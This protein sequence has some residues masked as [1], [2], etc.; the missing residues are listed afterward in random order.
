MLAIPP[1]IQPR[2]NQLYAQ[3]FSVIM[4][5]IAGLHALMLFVSLAYTPLGFMPLVLSLN[6]LGGVIAGALYLYPRSPKDRARYAAYLLVLPAL[7]VVASIYLQ[8]FIIADQILLTFCLLL[9]LGTAFTTH[10]RSVFLSV[11]SV[12]AVLFVTALLL[13]EGTNVQLFLP[14]LVCAGALSFWAFVERRLAMVQ[15]LLAQARLDQTQQLLAERGQE[16]REKVA[17]AEDASKMKSEFIASTSHEIKTALSGI[18]SAMDALSATEISDEQK[19][20]TNT[21]HYS[22]KALQRVLDDIMDTTKLE[23]GELEILAEPFSPA[24][25]V[26]IATSLRMPEARKKGLHLTSHVQKKHENINLFGD[27]TRL[28]QVLQNLLGN[29]IRYTETGN[30]AVLLEISGRGGNRTLR[31]AVQDTGAGMTPDEMSEIFKLKKDVSQLLYRG[32][33]GGGLGLSISQELMNI[34]GGKL[35]AESEKGTGSVFYMEISLPLVK[36]VPSEK[37]ESVDDSAQAVKKLPKTAAHILIAEDN[38]INR[39]LIRS[40]LATE[41]YELEFVSDGLQALEVVSSESLIPDLILMD[42]QM[43]IMDGREATRAIR[44]L[45]DMDRAS[46]PIVAL[47]ANVDKSGFNIYA[48]D[49]IDEV[50]P[51]PIDQG[52]L[53][54]TIRQVLYC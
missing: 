10:A 25:L 46:V 43:P 6:V 27:G 33:A 48:E 42:I 21:A 31:I 50:V 8:L 3:R 1:E 30:V 18:I 35:Y 47:T 2:L 16:L 54:K 44:A 53:L 41:N 45:D 13:L 36:A 28:A 15:S 23:G 19:V 51:K 17:V 26:T 14:A 22:A 4:L 34:M 11:L 32:H 39:L 5:L 29:A 7:M 38:E 52:Q 37:S 9:M 49:G 24:A 12:Q 20:L 40:M